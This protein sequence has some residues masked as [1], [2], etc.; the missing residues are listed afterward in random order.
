MHLSHRRGFTLIELL[1]V[2]SIIAL[3]IG[4]LLPAL[5]STRVAARTAKCASNVNQLGKLHFDQVLDID[6]WAQSAYD[7][8]GGRLED[9][10]PGAESEYNGR[11][12]FNFLKNS[13]LSDFARKLNQLEQSVP[14]QV[15]QWTIPCPEAIE[16]REQSY[17]MSYRAYQARPAN[18]IPRMIVFACSP[19]RL[20]VRGR[21]LNPRHRDRVNFM[22]GDSHVDAGNEDRIDDDDLF[23][24]TTRLPPIPAEYDE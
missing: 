8:R 6:R 9:V 2:I 4:I 1:V 10:A 18:V 14:G 23:R 15:R 16:P 13:N 20:M 22:Y 19:Y 21:D 7:L 17:G 11:N 12:S 5:S 24:H 3:L